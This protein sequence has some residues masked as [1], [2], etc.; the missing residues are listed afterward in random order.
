MRRTN[1]LYAV[2]SM[3]LVVL[4]IAAAMCA[5]CAPR[6]TDLGATIIAEKE[7]GE[8]EKTITLT[9]VNGAKQIPGG[10]TMAELTGILSKYRD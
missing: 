8:G 7:V 3:L 1:R 4:F 6:M 10:K 2:L 5:S 9:V